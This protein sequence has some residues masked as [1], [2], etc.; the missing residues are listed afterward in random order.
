MK[1]A[2]RA[3]VTRGDKLLV[4]HR[5]K[6]GKEYYTLPGG[7]VE[8]G[9]KTEQA[10][11]RELQEETG[12][13]ITKYQLVFIEEA[14][15]PYGTQYIFLCDDPGGDIGLRADSIEAEL[16]KAGQNTFTPEWL[17]LSMLTSEPFVSERLKRAILKCV[18]GGF[19]E[20]P[21]KL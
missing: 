1:Q 21:E 2:A 7:A 5:N 3:I 9:E 13:D 12:L 18:E 20:Q 14:G 17:E 11:V 10:M 19:P 6:F 8:M 4:M 15:P 16:N